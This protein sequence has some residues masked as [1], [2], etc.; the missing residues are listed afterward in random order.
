MRYAYKDCAQCRQNLR[1]S[2]LSAG[3]QEV[4]KQE[5]KPFVPMQSHMRQAHLLHILQ[6]ANDIE[7]FFSHMYKIQK[8]KKKSSH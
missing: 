3:Q 5:N 8:Y 2:A 4:T 6:V 7:Q 1:Q